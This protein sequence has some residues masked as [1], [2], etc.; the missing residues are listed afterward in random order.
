MDKKRLKAFEDMLAA[1]CKQYD[2]T[3]EKNGKVQSQRQGENRYLSPASCNFRRYCP[4]TGRMDLL[5]KQKKL[6]IKAWQ[7]N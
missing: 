7:I 5:V 1:I 6:V 3:T 4:I 2:E